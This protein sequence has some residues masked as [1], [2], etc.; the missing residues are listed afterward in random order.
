MSENF[1]NQVV[2]LIRA[3]YILWST[4]S[5]KISSQT[6]P[7]HKTATFFIVYCKK[8]FRLPWRVGNRR[9]NFAE[10]GLEVPKWEW[11]K[12]IVLS[13]TAPRVVLR[14]NMD[15]SRTY[16]NKTDIG[17]RTGKKNSLLIKLKLDESFIFT[18]W[19]VRWHLMYAT[20]TNLNCY[21]L[22]ASI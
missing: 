17:W 20:R 14:H 18:W 21:L 8:L 11:C 6:I 15:D 13:I 19:S 22:F 7:I 2:P 9:E 10:I 4:T 1:R 3:P 12:Y 16:W 5:T